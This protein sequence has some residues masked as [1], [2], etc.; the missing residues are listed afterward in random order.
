MLD[1]PEEHTAFSS[2]SSSR[3]WPHGYSS[4]EDETSLDFLLAL[5]LQSD[6][7][8]EEQVAEG[9][10]GGGVGLWTD[11]WEQRLQRNPP[12]SSVP[13]AA[14]SN[15]NNN[16]AQH[17]A[18]APGAAQHNHHKGESPVW[19]SLGSVK[20]LIAQRGRVL[21]P[22][23]SVMVQGFALFFNYRTPLLFNT[24]TTGNYNY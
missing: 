20:P 8:P 1:Y 19:V 13:F 18:A 14:P 12:K 23:W 7:G 16:N 17:L 9:G 6:P 15:N 3:A 21:H 24:K 5:S 22:D 2:T 10:G 4:A 11:V